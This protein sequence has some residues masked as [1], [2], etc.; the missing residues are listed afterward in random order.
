MLFCSLPFKH[1]HVPF[2]VIGFTLCFISVFLLIAGVGCSDWVHSGDEGDGWREGLFERCALL[3]TP[4]PLPFNM[5][6][7]PGCVRARPE[8]YIRGT[9]ALV[10]IAIFTTFFG[11]L[12]TGLGLRSTDPN[13]KYKYY[14]V[15]IYALVASGKYY[16]NG[17]LN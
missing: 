9:A 7:V 15:A 11:T 2:Q 1:N 17:L 3:G 10:I 14:R 8:G 4:T 12:L 13:K 6:A 16:Y 5:E